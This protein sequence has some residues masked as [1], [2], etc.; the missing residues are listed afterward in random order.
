MSQMVLNVRIRVRVFVGLAT[1]LCE[2]EAKF[3]G[4][5]DVADVVTFVCNNFRRLNGNT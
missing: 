4:L 1:G 3:S 5:Q 2:A